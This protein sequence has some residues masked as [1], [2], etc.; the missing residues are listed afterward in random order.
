VTA[1]DAER[2]LLASRPILVPRMHQEEPLE[3]LFT[4]PATSQWQ[5]FLPDGKASTRSWWRRSTLQRNDWLYAVGRRWPPAEMRPPLWSRAAASFAARRTHRL[6]DVPG[7]TRRGEEPLKFLASYER[8]RELRIRP[9]PQCK[10]TRP[11]ARLL[12]FPPSLF[13]KN[14]PRIK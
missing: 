6:H 9:Y 4:C 7:I 8:R 14:T 3:H 12:G 1:P 13:T 2:S 5:P 10:F 11:A